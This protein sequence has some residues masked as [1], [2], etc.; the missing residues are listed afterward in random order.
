M[1]IKDRWTYKVLWDGECDNI[2]EELEAAAK[3]GANLDRAN[4]DGANLDGANLDRANLV[5]ASLYRA[6]LDGASL[7]RANLVGA[8]L[9]GASLDRASLDR[10]SLDGASLVGA[11]L[12][13]ASLDGAGLVGA[14]LYRANLD[15]ANLDG[16]KNPPI[17]SHDFWAELLLRA[18]GDDLR[19]RMVA[20]LVLVSRDW[21]WPR[22]M[23][24]MTGELAQDWQEWAGAVFWHWP[25]MCRNKGLPEI[26]PAANT[27]GVAS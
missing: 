4:L 20:G 3:A 5:G 8:S 26:V 21:C 7:D 23:K 12:Y 27:A 1:Q 15:G 16:V 6:S 14:S 25:E 2:R 10:A 17:D 13:S 22:M 11:S 19:R 24:L 9:D 18:A